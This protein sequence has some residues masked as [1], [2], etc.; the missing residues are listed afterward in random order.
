MLLAAFV[1]CLCITLRC[2]PGN[3]LVKSYFSANC[4]NNNNNNNMGQRRHCSVQ[5]KLFAFNTR[6]PTQ[7]RLAM[8]RRGL[9]LTWTRTLKVS[10]T[11][12][13]THGY[14]HTDTHTIHE[15]RNIVGARTH[16]RTVKRN[17]RRFY[18][19]NDIKSYL[20]T[21]Y[22]VWRLVQVCD[23]SFRH[24]GFI[25]DECHMGRT[26]PSKRCLISCLR[27]KIA[28][29]NGLKMT[30]KLEKPSLNIFGNTY[31]YKNIFRK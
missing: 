10:S 25:F 23:G 18:A 11:L 4:N 19:A 5:L 6:S 16:T 24:N 31:L 12:A 13:H 15:W 28:A 29:S 22:D 9:D 26:R 3:N 20:R 17:S 1:R 21:V 27:A 7:R 2:A 8:G 14:T 30:R